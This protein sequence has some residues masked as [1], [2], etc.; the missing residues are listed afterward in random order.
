LDNTE[1]LAQK[2]LEI[3][4]DKGVNCIL[5]AVGGQL[6]SELLKSIATNGQLITYGLLSA[7]NVEY[8]NATIIFKNIII[9]GFGIDAWLANISLDKKTTI[10]DFL[11]LKLKSFI[12]I[13]VNKFI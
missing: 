6:I 5:D 8:H 3:T 1:E 7:Q 11:I 9:K 10:I 2:I 4:K 12:I 13:K